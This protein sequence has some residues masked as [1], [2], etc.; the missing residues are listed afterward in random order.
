MIKNRDDILMGAPTLEALEAMIAEFLQSCHAK[1]I[2]LK[3]TKFLIS[4]CVE[5]GGCRIS[6]DTL[7]DKG[8]VFIQPNEQRV[9]AFEELKRPCTKREAQAWLG[10]VSSL[11][12]WAPA[13]SLACP[14]LRKA[15]AGASK[16]LQT[17][18]D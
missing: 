7:N 5:F 16:L 2:K 3:G 8:F 15:S 14:L 10:I 9:R 18:E 1:N 6:H 13:T 11:A 12:A 4:T 17:S